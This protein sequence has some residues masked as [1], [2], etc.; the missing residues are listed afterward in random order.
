MLLEGKNALITGSRRG[1]GWA[2]V[3]AFAHEGCNIWACARTHD[4]AFEHKLSNL[5]QECGVWIRPIYFDM[6]DEGAMKEA[7]KSI[8]AEKLPIDI[9]VN[10]AGMMVAPA[11]FQMTSIDRFREVFEVN[12]FSQM[13]LTQYVVRIMERQKGGSIVNVSSVAGI[14]SAPGQTEYGSSKA[15]IA[16]ATKKLASEFGLQGIRVNAVAPGICETDM[17]DQIPDEVLKS[18]LDATAL[19]RKGRPEEV[20][21]V[22]AFLASDRASY[23]TG[24][25]LRIDGG[26]LL[27]LDRL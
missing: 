1:I 7:I 16:L 11:S 24:Q 23:V 22:I 25:I 14:D 19:G 21:Q 2:T 4:E 3:E 5:S 15:A 27:A 20:A 13:R 10:N 9:L 6:V 17:G 12:F 18:I 26:G 8:R